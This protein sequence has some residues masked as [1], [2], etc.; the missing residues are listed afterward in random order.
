MTSGKPIH[1]WIVSVS[2]RPARELPS[3]DRPG[4]V[5]DPFIYGLIAKLQAEV[6]EDRRRQSSRQ[7]RP[8]SSRFEEMSPTIWLRGAA[9]PARAE[10]EITWHDWPLDFSEADFDAWENGWAAPENGGNLPR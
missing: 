4:P 6:R 8:G 1:C 10:A 7:F 2:D 5:A 3:G 9:L